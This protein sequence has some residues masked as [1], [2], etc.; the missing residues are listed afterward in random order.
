M[1]LEPADWYIGT[2]ID[3]Q[4]AFELYQKAANLGDSIAQ[5]NLALM[6]EKGDEIKKDKNQA[7]YWYEKSAEQ[8]DK[9]AQN[10]IKNLKKKEIS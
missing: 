10:K 1:N 7:I 2:N 8:G 5:Y 6:Y 3:K 4:K 9:Y